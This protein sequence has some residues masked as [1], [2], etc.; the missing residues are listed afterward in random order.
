MNPMGMMGQWAPMMGPMMGDPSMMMGPMGYGPMGFMGPMGPM[1]P[2]IEQR[3]KEIITLKNMTLYPPPSKH[4]QRPS[5]YV[6]G[7]LTYLLLN[8]KLKMNSK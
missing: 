2:G 4:S 3:P 8:E 7:I 6:C 5:L 1:G